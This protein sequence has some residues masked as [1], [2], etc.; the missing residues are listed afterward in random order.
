MD[1][2]KKSTF[3]LCTKNKENSFRYAGSVYVCERI[4]SAT[5]GRAA[6]S[7]TG[8]CRKTDVLGRG[9]GR[10]EENKYRFPE[11]TV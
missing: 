1:T 9:E 10:N 2:G 11:H 3:R 8:V 6:L 4:R 5:K 7:S